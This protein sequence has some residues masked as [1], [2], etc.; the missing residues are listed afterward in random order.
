MP[1]EFRTVAK[2]KREVQSSPFLLHRLFRA[3]LRPLLTWRGR[4]RVSEE[5]WHL[6]LAGGVGVIGGAINLVFTYSSDLIGSILWSW[7]DSAK[8]LSSTT[9]IILVTTLGGLVAGLLLHFGAI[10]SHASSVLLEGS[11][12]FAALRIGVVDGFWGVAGCCRVSAAL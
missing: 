11:S 6:A 2:P 12:L 5:A 10:G 4:I 7:P 8:A 1:S 3:F 9:A